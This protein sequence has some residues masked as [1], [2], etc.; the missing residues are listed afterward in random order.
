MN[1][2]ELTKIYK[3]YNLTK[4]DVYSD[5]RGFSIITR[6]GVEKIKLDRNIQVEY[7]PICC[8]LENVVLKATS[9]L[10]DQDGEW[11]RQEETFGTASINNCRS[12]FLAEIA[13]KR[14]LAR[15][16]IKTIGLFN[17]HGKDE[18]DHQ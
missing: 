15:V 9:Y 17:T 1:R 2:N 6:S 8:S 10:Q 3:D 18:L 16:V 12:H 11:Q 5:K 7:E 14:A 13:E 4:D